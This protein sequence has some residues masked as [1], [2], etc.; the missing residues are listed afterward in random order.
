MQPDETVLPYAVAIAALEEIERWIELEPCDHSVNLCVC[1][2]KAIAD[3][4]RKALGLP[5]RWFP[6]DVAELE[7]D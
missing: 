3:D 2:S 6:T 5:S 7:A 1:G 4:Y